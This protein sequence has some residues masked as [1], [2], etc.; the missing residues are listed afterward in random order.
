MKSPVAKVPSKILV[1]DVGGSHVKCMF[2][3]ETTRRKFASGPVLTPQKMVEGVLAIVADWAFDAVSI[4]YP[5]VVQHG[6]PALDPHHLAPGW[7]GFDF[8]GAFGRPVRIVND[9]AMQ[10]LGSYQGGKM[11]FLGLGTGLGSALI[12]DGHIVAMEL[13]HLRRS[14]K[15]DYEDLLGKKGFKRLGKK[16]W[17]RKVCA[18]VEGFSAA[19][20]PDEIVVGGGQAERLKKLPSRTRRTD[21]A[22]AFVGGFRLWDESTPDASNTTYKDLS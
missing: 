8:E 19:L 14:K 4:G 10:A 13:G 12:V 20:L 3:G 11:L 6:I 16:K 21:N 9:A 2:S 17:R 15:H 1:I 18:V 7:I 22:A 5:G